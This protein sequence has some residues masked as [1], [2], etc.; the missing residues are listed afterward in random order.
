MNI[1]LCQIEDYLFYLLC[2]IL[3]IGFIS[4]LAVFIYYEIQTRKIWTYTLKSTYLV[5]KCGVWS[6]EVLGVYD[7]S[8]QAIKDCNE[9]KSKEKDDYHKFH[10]V[11]YPVNMKIEMP[12]NKIEK[13]YTI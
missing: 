13:V 7:N 2:A 1:E 11:E 3:V 8:D 5:L 10:V 6:G 4:A 9:F 12:L